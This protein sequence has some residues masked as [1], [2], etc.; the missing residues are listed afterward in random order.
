MESYIKAGVIFIVYTF[1]VFLGFFVLSAPIDSLID[2]FATVE[3]PN[4]QAEYDQQ[5]SIT[6]TVIKIF[7][8]LFL[9]LPFAWLTG[10]VFSREPAFGSYR[11]Y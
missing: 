9:G 8:A 5:I 6:Q 3:A 7:F 2:S 1:T 4:N 11:R 10:W